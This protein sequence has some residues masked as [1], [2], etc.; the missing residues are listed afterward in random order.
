[1]NSLIVIKTA[2]AIM[3]ADHNQSQHKKVGEL[4]ALKHSE[5]LLPRKVHKL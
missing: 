1:M 3:V 4:V 5:R 2:D